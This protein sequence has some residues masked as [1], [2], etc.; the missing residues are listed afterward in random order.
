MKRRV[1]FTISDEAYEALAKISQ[2]TGLGLSEIVRNAIKM[3]K[4]AKEET[5]FGNAIIAKDPKGVS[6]VEKHLVI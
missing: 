5:A 4:W 6:K 1:N 2:E 3:Y